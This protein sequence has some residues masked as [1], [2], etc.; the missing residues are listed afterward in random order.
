MNK[1]VTLTYSIELDN[2]GDECARLLNNALDDLQK[3]VRA[4]DRNYDNDNT[5]SHSTIENINNLRAGLNNVDYNFEDI[6]KIIEGYLNY[7]SGMDVP[8][9][10]GQ[11]DMSELKDKIEKFKETTAQQTEK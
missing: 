10:T 9:A 8:A 4:V 7:R 11:A 5:L 6:S 3:L 2:L 1:R